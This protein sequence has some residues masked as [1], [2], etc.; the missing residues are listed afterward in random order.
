MNYE[1]KEAPVAKT[2]VFTYDIFREYR[3]GLYDTKDE[4]GAV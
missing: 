3:P 4:Q 2:V 1:P